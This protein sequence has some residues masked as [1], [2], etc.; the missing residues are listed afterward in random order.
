VSAREK[1]REKEKSGVEGVE[2]KATD[3]ISIQ[4]YIK[5]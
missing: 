3:A 2:N 4:N 5:N 1:E